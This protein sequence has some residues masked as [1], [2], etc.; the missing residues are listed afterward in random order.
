M[1]GQIGDGHDVL[2]ALAGKAHHKVEL[3][4]VP[5]GLE[6]RLGRTVQV[7]L[8]HVLV[9][10]VAHALAAGLG[11]ER[12]AALLFAGDRLSHI[13]AKRIQALRRNRHANTRIL[14]ATVEP[15]EHV[16]NAGVVGRGERGQRHLVIA[17]LFQALNH[18]RDDLVG[19]A[20]A[21]RAIRHAGLAKTTAAGAAAKD[22]DRQ[23]VVD[24]LRIGHAR[25][26]Q[27]IRGTE[28]LDDALEDHRRRILA[29]TRHGVAM[30]R[31]G[32]VVTHLVERRHVVA[33]NGCKLLNNLRARD[34][35]VT[36]AAMQ[37]TGLEQRFLTLTDED[38]IEEG[39][40]RLGVVHRGT[41]GDD[42]GVVFASVG[43]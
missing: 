24:Q 30:R 12:Q 39:R 28:I 35:F 22:L 11:R 23:A 34:S 32:L 27:R 8:G 20:L 3:H 13:H 38:G 1:I 15:A 37:L 43:R 42:D 25:L 7:L 6:G 31:A 41:A 19:R 18:R 16:A 26:R 2:V 9:N 29:L 17:S 36:Q 33:G 10:D 5:A 40:V 21:H 14:Q 4:A